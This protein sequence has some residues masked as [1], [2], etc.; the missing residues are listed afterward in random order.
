MHDLSRRVLCDPAQTITLVER[1]DRTGMTLIFTTALS[2][3]SAKWAATV[4]AKPQVEAACLSLRAPIARRML[5]RTC[6]THLP[7]D[8]QPKWPTVSNPV[9]K[10][11]STNAFLTAFAT[12]A[13]AIGYLWLGTLC[14]SLSADTA[15]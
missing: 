13:N 5:I 8:L 6:N 9:V 15:R 12:Q 1:S 4:G 14:F 7:V 2:H 3:F 10:V 11:P